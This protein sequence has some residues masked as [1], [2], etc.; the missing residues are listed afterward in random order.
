MSLSNYYTCKVKLGTDY[1][2]FPNTT[3]GEPSPLSTL[4]E[5]NQFIETGK[6]WETPL[7]FSVNNLTISEGDLLL[8][9]ITING[10]VYTLNKQVQ[11]DSER[12]GYFVTLFVELWI[13]NQKNGLSEFN[14]RYVSLTLKL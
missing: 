3:L 12:T 9:S 2:G 10:H 14:N 6:S 13:Y 11:Y 4:Y 5:F 1:A 8:E 7:T